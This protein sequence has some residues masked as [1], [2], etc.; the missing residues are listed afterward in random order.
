MKIHVATDHAV[1]ELNEKIKKYLQENGYEI[2]SSKVLYDN[3]NKVNIIQI[4]LPL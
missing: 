4:N 3:K 2:T 1:F